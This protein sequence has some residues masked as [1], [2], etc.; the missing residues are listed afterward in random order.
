MVHFMVV[1]VTEYHGKWMWLTF[2]GWKYDWDLN[3][4]CIRVVGA[5]HENYIATEFH[6]CRCIR[7]SW[8]QDV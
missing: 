1:D 8:E 3:S 6:G 4:Y 5:F 7:I 2:M